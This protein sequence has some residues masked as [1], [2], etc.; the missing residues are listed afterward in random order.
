M[1]DTDKFLVGVVIV[2]L[3]A[4]IVGLA[5]YAIDFNKKETACEERGG[6]YDSYNCRTIYVPMT[7]YCGS[8]CTNTIIVPTETCDHHCVGAT[9]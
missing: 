5:W 4:C 1:N 6:S 3:V 2:V 7:T 8:G 9:R